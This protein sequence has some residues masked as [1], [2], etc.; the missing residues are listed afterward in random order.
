METSMDE[1]IARFNDRVNYD[2]VHA[3]CYKR[4]QESHRAMANWQASSCGASPARGP[5]HRAPR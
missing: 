2:T 1:I 5:L 4:A 3:A